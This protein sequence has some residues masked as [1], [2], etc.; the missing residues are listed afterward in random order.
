MASSFFRSGVARFAT[1]STVVA[2]TLGA[3]A[4][5]NDNKLNPDDNANNGYIRTFSAS[6]SQVAGVHTDGSIHTSGALI[7]DGVYVGSGGAT[8]VGGQGIT[9]DANNA[10][11]LTAAHSGT[12]IKATTAFSPLTGGGEISSGATIVGDGAGLFLVP[13]FA[14]GWTLTS[15]EIGVNTAGTTGTT[16]VQ[17][18][19]PDKGRDMLSTKVTIDSAEKSSLTAATAAVINTSNDDVQGGEMINFDIDAISTTAAKDLWYIIQL[20]SP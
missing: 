18:R 2:I 8:I 4:T 19:Q 14:S 16:D 13:N 15:I 17:L 9:I 7:I 11:T 5:A 10:V 3:L 6:G 20:T 1:V 12:L